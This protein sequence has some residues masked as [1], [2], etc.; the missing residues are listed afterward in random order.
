MVAKIPGTGPNLPG[1]DASLWGQLSQV[2]RWGSHSA[3]SR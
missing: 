1:Q 2:P 3:G